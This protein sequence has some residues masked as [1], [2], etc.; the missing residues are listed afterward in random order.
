MLKLRIDEK[1]GRIMGA[2]PEAFEVPKPFVEISEEENSIISQDTANIYFYKNKKFVAV[3]KAEIE[4]REKRKA[5]IEAE[6]ATLDNKRIRAVCEPSV[7]DET[8]GETW[9]DYYNSEI[10]SLREEYSNL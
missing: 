8:T 9:L 1:T 10:A 6:L 5:E 7:K 4:A 2:Y 3:P